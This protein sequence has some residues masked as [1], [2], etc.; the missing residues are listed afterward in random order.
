M[1]RHLLIAGLVA[2]FFLSAC[3][4]PTGPVEVTRF[5][6]P[7]KLSLLGR[8]AIAV[9]AGPG[10]DADS[11]ELKSYR[12][13]VGRELVKLGYSEV[14]AGEGAQVA[15]VRIRR[16]ILTAERE[17]GPVSVGVGGSTGSYGS[18]VGVGLGIDLSGKPKDQV[19]T[20]LAVVIR[21]R[22][23]GEPLWEGRAQFAVKQGAPL[24]ET[25]LA[26]ARLA[27]ALFTDFPGESG[28]TFE[29]K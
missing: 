8:G 21:Q 3:A 28:E 17:G 7:E 22:L 19:M 16:A 27:E 12:A 9:E 25:Q 10:M 23:T 4:S 2:P 18:G 6:A 1:K 14:A 24:A 20:E 13:A 5:H 29:V 15:E 11:L 26:A